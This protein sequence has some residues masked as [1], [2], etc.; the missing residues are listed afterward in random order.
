MSPFI[1][2]EVGCEAQ[3]GCEIICVNFFDPR[4]QYWGKAALCRKLTRSGRVDC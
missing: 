3:P 2:E 4:R 1:L